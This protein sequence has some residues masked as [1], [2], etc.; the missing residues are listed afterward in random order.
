MKRIFLFFD[1]IK[2]KMLTR[3]IVSWNMN[4]TVNEKH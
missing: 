3:H 2:V 1:M 4:V